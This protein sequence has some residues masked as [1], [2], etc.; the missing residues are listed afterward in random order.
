MVFV[1]AIG[2]LL[3]TASILSID[4][5]TVQDFV[6]GAVC[7]GV[8]IACCFE[9]WRLSRCSGRL[10]AVAGMAFV[11]LVLIVEIVGAIMQLVRG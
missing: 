8:A 1:V 2:C 7:Q 11:G 4:K 10:I 6:V 9:A 5:F 3:S